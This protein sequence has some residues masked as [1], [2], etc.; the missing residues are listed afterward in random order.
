M[1]VEVDARKID[2]QFLHLNPKPF[3]WS[4]SSRNGQATVSKAFAI[5]ILSNILLYFLFLKNLV[6]SL[7]SLK[8]SCQ[9]R[10]FRKAPWFSPAI[11]G[12]TGASLLART[13]ENFFV[14]L[15]T[16]NFFDK[17]RFIN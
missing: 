3:L 12:R 10:P 14:R 6:G 17:G 9:E 8:L 11:F 2:I 7:T 5:S 13:L 4:T 15:W 16:R 1:L